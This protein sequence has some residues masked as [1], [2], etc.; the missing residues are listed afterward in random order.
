MTPQQL[1]TLKTAILA[2]GTLAQHAANGAVGAIVAAFNDLAA[3]DFYVW[4]TR[5]TRAEIYHQTSA[6]LSTFNWQIFKAQ[7]VSEQGAWREMFM[8]DQ[9]DF[10]LPNLR[11]GVANIFTGSAQQ[12]AQ[13]DHILAIAKRKAKRAEKLFADT[14]GGGTGAQATPAT[15]TFEG[16]ITAGDVEGALAS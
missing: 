13:R 15:L 11:A 9:A 1:T 12:N 3:P 10:S 7:S 14:S 4:R 8:G 5:V 6:E 16:E 2:D